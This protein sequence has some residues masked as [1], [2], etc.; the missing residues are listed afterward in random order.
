[1]KINVSNRNIEIVS[2]PNISDIA[3][4]YIDDKDIKRHVDIVIDDKFAQNSVTQITPY[5]EIASSEDLFFD[6]NNIPLKVNL[7]RLGNTWIY[8]PINSMEYTPANFE[9]DAL[10]KKAGIFSEKNIYNIKICAADQSNDLDLCKKLVNVFGNAG[11][12]GLCPANISIN[13]NKTEPESILEYSIENSDFVFLESDDGIALPDG[14]SIEDIISVQTNAWISVESFSSAKVVNTNEDDKYESVYKEGRLNN[15]YVSSKRKAVLNK[16]LTMDNIPEEYTDYEKE[17]LYDDVLLLSKDEKGSVIITPAEFLNDMKNNAAIIF[18]VIMYIYLKS[19]VKT[20]A[21][22]SWITDEP[23]DYR[24]YSYMPYGKYHERINVKDLV[25]DKNSSMPYSIIRVN[26]N[27]ENVFLVDIDENKELFFRKKGNDAK[28]PP[29]KSGEISFLTMKQTIVNYQKENIFYKESRANI[30]WHDKD[31]KAYIEISPLISSK[32]HI[33]VH[34]SVM[35]SIDDMTK[36]Y[37]LCATQVEAEQTSDVR[38]VDTRLYN[39]AND[40]IKIAEIIPKI[41]YGT[42]I[43]D[44]RIKGGGLPESYGDDYDMLDIGNPYG[45]PYRKGSTLIFRLPKNLI[46]YKDKIEE[47]VKKHIVADN[48][49]KFIYDK[50]EDG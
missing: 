26:T 44:I 43:Y 19:Y 20:K 5:Q 32:Y 34:D 49:V 15:F 46:Q 50:E 38:L 41:E 4:G 35:L 8:E 42:A 1:M 30:S 6:E 10:I 17:L 13:D 14:I 3:L 2:K 47:E 29:K 45:R 28:D 23:V 9:C 21:F 7:K 22:Y 33:I 39:S 18:D 12:R 27:N 40:G 25:D 48:I 36:K 24:V 31:A 37:W 11:Q 16:I